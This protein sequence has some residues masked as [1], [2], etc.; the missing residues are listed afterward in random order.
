MNEEK[1]WEIL[2]L[3]DWDKLGDDD[4]VC[5]PAIEALAQL[6]VEEIQRFEDLFTEKLHALDTTAHMDHSGELAS[7]S[8]DLFLYARCAAVTDGREE[9]E[10]ILADPAK[11]PKDLEFEALLFLASTA[12]EKKTGREWDYVSDL[13]YETGSNKEGWAD[14]AA[15]SEGL[16]APAPSVGEKKKWWQFWK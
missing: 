15:D 16:D 10:A 1:F 11:M 3:L 6:G 14:S 13:S 9:Y 5:K 7:D 12:Y 8:G 2:S 4:A